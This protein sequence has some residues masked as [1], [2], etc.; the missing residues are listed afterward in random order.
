MHDHDAKYGPGADNYG[1]DPSLIGCNCA[2]VV[3]RDPAPP[4]SDSRVERAARAIEEFTGLYPST[5]LNCA[6][7]ALTAADAVPV[8]AGEWTGE[9]P[10]EPGFWFWRFVGDTV[11]HVVEIEADDCEGY[12]FEYEGRPREWWPVP[13]SEP[14]TK[15][16]R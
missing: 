14:P 11:P 5:A 9:R 4:L 3:I 16:G 6:R 2:G 7:L 12:P 15:E 10:K 1:R 8:P 13:I